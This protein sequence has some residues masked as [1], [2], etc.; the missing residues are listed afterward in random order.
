MPNVL[1][2]GRATPRAPGSDMMGRQGAGSPCESPNGFGEIETIIHSIIIP[3]EG[4][5]RVSFVWHI[6]SGEMAAL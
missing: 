6:K 5:L 3:T 1:G 2:G 4:Q